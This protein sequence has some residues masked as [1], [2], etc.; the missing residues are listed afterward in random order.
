MT[1]SSNVVHL[2]WLA[3]RAYH[4]TFS[5]PGPTIFNWRGAPNRCK[6]GCGGMWYDR[7][8]PTNWW[9][10]LT[11]SLLVQTRFLL[12]LFL[13]AHK[14]IWLWPSVAWRAAQYARAQKGMP[15]SKGQPPNLIT[16]IFAIPFVTILWSLW[17]ISVALLI[18]LIGA[19]FII[20]T[21]AIA[22]FGLSL[23][24]SGLASV[25]LETHLT[26]S[27]ALIVAGILWEYDRNRRNALKQEELLGRLVLQ[28]RKSE[29]NQ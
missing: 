3:R 19:Q 2:K 23:V 4:E 21:I 28:L 6:C 16:P 10:Y 11:P 15:H 20:A 18:V 27:I 29:S 22:L 9:K 12:R 26:I 8:S 14:L 13:P 1:S 5:D 17:P 7:V 25:I 24:L